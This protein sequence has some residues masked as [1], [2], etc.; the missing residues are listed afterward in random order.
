MAESPG[1][2]GPKPGFKTRQTVM[3]L[4]PAPHLG[5]SRPP[6]DARVASDP[7]LPSSSGWEVHEK[8]SVPEIEA[9]VVERA[10]NTARM[11]RTA[12]QAPIAQAPPPEIQTAHPK[13]GTA[14]VEP[15]VPPTA[16]AL[17]HEEPHYGPRHGLTGT[18]DRRL[19]LIVD[20]HSA[21]SASF[22]LLRDSLLSR[23]LPRV[24]AVTSAT[25]ND[26]KT[27]CAVNLALALAEQAA[28]RV[29]LV[30]ANFFDPEL[31]TIFTLERL[32]PIAFDDTT[33]W[34]APYRIA[35]VTPTLH[36]AGVVR[37]PGE[38]MRFEQYRFDQMIDRLC[39]VA[40]DYI[41]IDTPAMRATPAVMQMITIADGTILAARSG[42]TASSDLRRAAEQ[43]PGKKALGIALVDAPQS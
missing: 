30:D 43:I 4:A 6:P 2:N 25:P 9:E 34:L 29:L 3:G 36:V 31:A 15:H 32:T 14:I 42:V 22:R 41:I 16:L 21:R 1:D 5:G 38:P 40:Y 10:P 8:Q 11:I 12:E 23:S 35:G 24:V 27:T 13:T 28:T 17:R 39:R 19:E 18:L 7:G 20:P 33:G 26:G 37:A